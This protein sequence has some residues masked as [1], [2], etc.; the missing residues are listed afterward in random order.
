MSKYF[1]DDSHASLPGGLR[2][3]PEKLRELEPELFSDRTFKCGAVCDADHP[4][5]E[6]R[7]RLAEH[8]D[9]A[10]AGPAKVVSVSPL[11]IA[12]YTTD[13]DAAVLLRFPAEFA[14][15]YRLAEGT[16]LLTVCSF[17]EARAKDG[18]ALLYAADLIP[19]P[20]R[21]NWSNFTPLIAEFLSDEKDLIETR[22][23][24]VP[25]G[26]WTSLDEKARLRVERW[27]LDTARD[28]RPSRAG[29]PVLR[30]GPY[31]F[32]SLEEL[33]RPPGLDKKLILKAVLAAVAVLALI[34]VKWLR[35]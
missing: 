12:V 22:K 33:D 14:E 20:A 31:W 9:L 8:L 28:G 19:G 5:K 27:G 10:C 34:L 30:G 6:I 13:L 15:R 35:R 16:R 23:R 2:L 4:A 11:V 7:E 25:A 1:N 18:G 3:S 26:E 21:T 32:R 24:E 17:E 29:L